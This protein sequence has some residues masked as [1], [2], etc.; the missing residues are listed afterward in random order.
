MSDTEG[1][2]ARLR[3]YPRLPVW[4]VEDHQEVSLRPKSQSPDSLQCRDWHLTLTEPEPSAV[5]WEQ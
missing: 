5:K 3:R 1:D 4:V 2:R